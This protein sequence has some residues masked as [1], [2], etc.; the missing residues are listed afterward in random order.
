[1]HPTTGLVTIVTKVPFGAS[2]VYE[3]PLPLVPNVPAVAKKVREIAPVAGT[4]RITSGS[5]EP[6]GRSVL[7]RTYTNVFLYPMAVGQSVS[8]ALA[9]TPCVAPAA[10]EAQGESIA[11]LESG[12][13]YVT[14]SEG[15]SAKMNFVDCAP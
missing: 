3:L 2:G 14:V 6:H 7:I 9:G 1:V 8:E 13:G 15:A 10:D 12:G 5:V 11:W 4:P